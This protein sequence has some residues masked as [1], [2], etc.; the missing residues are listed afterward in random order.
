[1]I[2]ESGI[3]VL[4]YAALHPDEAARYVSTDGAMNPNQPALITAA[5][6][7]MGQG[8]PGDHCGR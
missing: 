6:A 7:R 1:V 2:A 8:E 5:S 4:S 3:D